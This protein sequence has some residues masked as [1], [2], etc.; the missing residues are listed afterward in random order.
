MSDS[1]SRRD[2]IK[3]A[4]RGAA[5]IGL[6]GG[7]AYLGVRSSR[8]QVWQLDPGKCLNSRHG[9]L[10]V[11]ACDLCRTECVVH[12][13]AVRAVNDCADCGR[14]YICPAYY[15]VTSAV[16]P[17]GLPSEKLCPRDAIRRTPI[18]W[19]DPADPANN[20]YEYQIDEALCDGC[21]KCVMAC[22]EPAGLGSIRLAVRHDLCVNCNRCTIAIACPDEA[23]DRV[24]AEKPT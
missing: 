24:S 13:S 15:N 22:K 14:C 17:D 1:V 19:V 4:A 3:N 2:L 7:A 10:G 12:L 8:S 6:A 21:G 23:Y 11:P 20:F 18:G 16:G 9:A 5:V